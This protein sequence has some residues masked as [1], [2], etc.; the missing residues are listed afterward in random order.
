MQGVTIELIKQHQTEAHRIINEMRL[1]ISFENILNIQL[2]GKNINYYNH[3]AI[4]NHNDIVKVYDAQS[5]MIVHIP[6]HFFSKYQPNYLLGYFNTE[7]LSSH[8]R[9][10]DLMKSIIKEDNYEQQNILLDDVISI[11]F[12]ETYVDTDRVYIPEL[13]S[14]NALFSNVVHYIYQ[15][16]EEHITL[17]DL[18]D[19][20]FVSQSYI[21]ILFNR[22]I[23]LNFKT[24]IASLQI[25]LSLK[26]L[27]LS[28]DT[29]QN[30]SLAYGFTN[31]SNY[32]KQFK[33]LIGTSPVEY[34]K[35]LHTAIPAIQISN[36]DTHY[37][38]PYLLNHTS[39][40]TYQSNTHI[41]LDTLNPTTY[42]HRKFLFLEVSQFNTIVSAI[43]AKNHVQTS[44]HNE[45]YYLYFNRLSH[46]NLEFDNAEEIE[47]LCQQI[48][49]ANLNL[50]FKIDSVQL[51][52]KFESQ[53]L[54]PLF[55]VIAHNN[56]TFQKT[57]FN[58]NIV[59]D[60]DYLSVHDIDYMRQ[61]LKSQFASCQF[62]L[63]VPLPYVSQKNRII[64]QL[65]DQGITFDY[66]MLVFKDLNWATY[67]KEYRDETPF[68]LFQSMID[69]LTQ[70]IPKSNYHF[71][72]AD[73][74]E[75]FVK[76]LYKKRIT[77]YPELFLNLLLMFNHQVNGLSFPLIP[78]DEQ[79]LSFYNHYG[80]KN[81]IHL[82]YD[83]LYPFQDHYV[84]QTDRYIVSETSNA[85]HILL[86][87]YYHKLIK[88]RSSVHST[89]QYQVIKSDHL[90]KN[91]MATYRFQ[92]ELSNVESML[93]SNI[94]HYYIPT[95]LIEE[96]NHMNHLQLH[97]N[98]HDFINNDLNIT[99]NHREIKLIKI[100][101]HQPT[102]RHD[103][104]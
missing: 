19:H 4:L 1:M 55:K 103:L 64:Q 67:Q 85:Y 80:N 32:S 62:T 89:S 49:N 63:I 96:I 90:S 98:I 99:L 58:L 75:S 76:I 5:I 30:I 91:M 73:L 29:I 24:Y 51:L 68:E 48:Q 28:N 74:N 33:S 31:Y 66:Y 72:L 10:K 69:D 54:K 83:M 52:K 23:G 77:D 61:H 21:S 95:H 18:A 94:Q 35:S 44:N 39:T 9:I 36:F 82:V 34:R 46:M 87:D 56:I 50:A 100:F 102:L 57:S 6:L 79:S 41:H 84:T 59:L 40:N 86:F 92:N 42:I 78:K 104:Y 27:L 101:K 81:A 8:N 60:V 71:I 37:F 12:K 17:K 47:W 22:Y 2:N 88:P 7:K 38:E 3:I 15:H 70:I 45:H 97:V 11:I 93:P 13:W 43:K 14:Q 25:N 53:F 20:F 26:H 16:R 65:F